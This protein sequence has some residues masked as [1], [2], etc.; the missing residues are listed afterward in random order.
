MK[1]PR[2]RFPGVNFGTAASF[3]AGLWLIAAPW[4][5]RTSAD[6]GAWGSILVGGASG[7]VAILRSTAGPRGAIISWFNV[8]LG[9][10]MIASPW[11]F[12]YADQ[13]ARAWNSAAVGVLVMVL[14]CVAETAPEAWGA[15]DDDYQAS[16]G[17]D[18]PYSVP[19][20]PGEPATWYEAANYGQAGL[21][22]P[23]RDDATWWSPWR[24]RL[25]GAR[26]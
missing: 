8:L 21:G 25:F 10:S 5:F 20:R 4:I 26:A 3:L 11:I 14:S 12:A 19:E 13:S 24:R 1:L 17:W 18:Y 23:E 2:L 7:L 16:P 6:A 15:H 9:A 22:D